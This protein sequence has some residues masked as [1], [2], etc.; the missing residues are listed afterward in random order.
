MRSHIPL[1]D[2]GSTP[3]V[4]SSRMTV[5]ELAMN[6]IATESFLFIP[7]DK[8]RDCSCRLSVS[9]TSSRNLKNFESTDPSIPRG[10]SYLTHTV[11]ENYITKTKRTMEYENE[12]AKIGKG[13]SQSRNMKYFSSL[14]TNTTLITCQ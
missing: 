12:N 7:P 11:R 8:L 1:L 5:L 14:Y 3:D 4:G 2:A 13:E 9:P 10:S 6:A